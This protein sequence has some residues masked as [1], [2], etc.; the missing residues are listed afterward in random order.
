MLKSTGF[1]DVA[2][3]RFSGPSGSGWLY[4]HLWLYGF[5]IQL[6]EMAFFLHPS[7]YS[8]PPAVFF[9]LSSMEAEKQVFVSC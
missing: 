1:V 8:A 2:I 7:S 4:K 5:S 9:H 3:C 6:T